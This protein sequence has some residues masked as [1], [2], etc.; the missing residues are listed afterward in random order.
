MPHVGAQDKSWAHK[1]TRQRLSGIQVV[2]SGWEALGSGENDGHVWIVWESPIGIRLEEIFDR[3]GDFIP[4]RLRLV[5]GRDLEEIAAK[6][7]S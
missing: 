5:D 2:P 4:R 1:H 7:K 6:L 3:V